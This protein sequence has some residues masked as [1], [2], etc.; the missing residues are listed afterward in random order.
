MKKRYWKIVGYD[1]LTRIYEKEIPVDLIGEKREKEIKGWRR[2]KKIAL[3]ESR[4]PAWEDLA[5]KW[6]SEVQVPRRC[7]PR[8]DS[9]GKLEL[10][11]RGM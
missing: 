9:L 3:I 8:D 7:A 10:R 5:V 6:F 2:N 1:A 11:N 4:N